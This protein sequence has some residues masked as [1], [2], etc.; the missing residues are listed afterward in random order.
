MIIDY[1]L[2]AVCVIY[3]AYHRIYQK[4]KSIAVQF[5]YSSFKY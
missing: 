5:L 4:P 3:K 2:Y 1:V